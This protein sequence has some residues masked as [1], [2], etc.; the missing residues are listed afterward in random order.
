MSIDHCPICGEKDIKVRKI[1]KRDTIDITCPRCNSYSITEECLIDEK[2]RK[3]INTNDWALSGLLQN[4]DRHHED[5]LITTQN[6]NYLLKDKRIPSKYDIERKAYL[7]LK[8]LKSKT[9]FFGELV[10]IEYPKSLAICFAKNRDEFNSLAKLLEDWGLIKLRTDLDGSIIS[11]LTAKT[12]SLLKIEI[13]SKQAFIANWFAEEQIDTISTIENAIR[14]AGYEPMCIKDKQ[15]KEIIIQKALSEIRNSSFII[16]N[17]TGMRDAVIY[18]AGFAEG[19]GLE[20]I[21]IRDK[22]EQEEKNEFYTGHYKI[23]YYNNLTNLREI[24]PS[25]IKARFP[26]NK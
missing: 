9:Q 15:Y 6:I 22:K 18:E 19:L 10:E 20:S 8:K 3:I 11:S 21:F 24:L 17:L 2:V 5:T 16:V 4:M 25:I 13:S 1:S 26:I 7:L 12:F 14:E 23:N